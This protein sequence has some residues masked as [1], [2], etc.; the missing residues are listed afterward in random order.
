MYAIDE[1]KGAGFDVWTES[2]KIR[3]KQV[4]E[5]PVDEIWM[6]NLLQNIKENKQEVIKYLQQEPTP[7][8]TPKQNSCPITVPDAELISR[9]LKYLTGISEDLSGWTLWKRIEQGKEHRFATDPAGAVRW[10]RWYL[11]EPRLIL[12]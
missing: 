3:Y 8:Q 5:G 2:G 6:N 4:T 1:L 12:D 10:E 7:K 9:D 11:L